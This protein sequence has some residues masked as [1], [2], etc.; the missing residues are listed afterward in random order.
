MV[1]D[2]VTIPDEYEALNFDDVREDV[3]ELY[4]RSGA[5]NDELDSTYPVKIAGNVFESSFVLAKMDPDAYRNAQVEWQE[6]RR[7][8]WLQL[9]DSVLDDDAY[10]DNRAQF[11]RVVEAI[12]AGSIIP[13]VGSGVGVPCGNPTWSDFLRS[14]APNHILAAVQQ[15]LDDGEFEEAAQLIADDLGR[16]LFWIK[17]ENRLTQDIRL[18]GPILMLAETFG[19][20]CVVTTNF[21]PLLEAA[22]ELM[23]E[24]FC[25]VSTLLTPGR[26]RR[27]LDE[28][29]D[30]PQLLKMH[31]DAEEENGRVLT[32]DEFNSHYGN[33]AIDFTMPVPALAQRLLASPLLFVGCGLNDD[34]VLQLA[35]AVV[36]AAAPPATRHYAILEAPEEEDPHLA[37]RE[38]VL[39]DAH[40][41]PIWYP[42]GEHDAVEALLAALA[43]RAR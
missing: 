26:F 8:D 7:A 5:F 25:H 24:R 6:T 10:P 30:V 36:D 35:R 15:H 9:A 27:A 32:L 33:G 11:N 23:G 21:D 39:G 41:F 19:A 12:R 4:R 38:R 31:G 17:L 42:S 43:D 40:I 13:F 16:P 22:F 34:R 14:L 3:A 1:G 28:G 37:E 2:G 18:R 20:G 29:R